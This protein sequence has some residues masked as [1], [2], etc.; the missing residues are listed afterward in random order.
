M[1]TLTTLTAVAALIAGM[2]IVSAQSSMSSDKAGAMGSS[3]QV[4]GTGKSFLKIRVHSSASM[5][6]C[7]LARR[8]TPGRTA[9]RIRR[10]PPAQTRTRGETCRPAMRSPRR[11]ADAG[12]Y[13]VRA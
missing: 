10:R 13:D 5:P 6:A 3:A 12:F 4:T 9:R 2:S 8:Q 7:R 1:K 11:L